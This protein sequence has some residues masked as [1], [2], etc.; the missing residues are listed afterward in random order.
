MNDTNIFNSSIELDC[1]C[2]DIAEAWIK[3]RKRENKK[4]S[5]DNFLDWAGDFMHC[6]ELNFEDVYEEE[7]E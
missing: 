5:L 6:L 7:N 3:Y 1:F 4:V 2:M